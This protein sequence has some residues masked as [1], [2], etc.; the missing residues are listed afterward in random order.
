MVGL[1]EKAGSEAS[2]DQGIIRRDHAAGE[3]VIR[4]A[5][6]RDIRRKRAQSD[7]ADLGI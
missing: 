6:G 5:G 4:R 7:S 1:V 2:E 3:G